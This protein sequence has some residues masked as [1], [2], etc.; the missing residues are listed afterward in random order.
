MDAALLLGAKQRSF[1]VGAQTKGLVP[2]PQ[3]MTGSHL[4]CIG[5][6][7]DK[8]HPSVLILATLGAS[9]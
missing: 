2:A 7:G 5:G 1:D 6:I 3:Q 9:S 4:M 8:A